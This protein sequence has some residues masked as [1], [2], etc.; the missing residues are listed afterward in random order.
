MTTPTQT[1]QPPTEIP[2]APLTLG[3]NIRKAREEKKLTQQEL[4]TQI[5][6]RG[7]DAGAYISRI[8]ADQQEPRIK[9]TRRIAQ[10]LGVSLEALI[11]EEEG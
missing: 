4:A 8:E 6:L 5:G 2:T 11:P 10:A 3:Q 9:R 7:E 1:T